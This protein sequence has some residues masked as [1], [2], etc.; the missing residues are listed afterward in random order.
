MST[1]T[2]WRL[3]SE[4]LAAT[5]SFDRATLAQ[6]LGAHLTAAEL[7]SAVV[8]VNAGQRPYVA[9][10]GCPGCAAGRCVTGCHVGL[11]SRTLRASMGVDTRLT[12]VRLGFETSGYQRYLWAWP[13]KKAAQ[14]L[15]GEV[16]A[17]WPRARLLARWRPGRDRWS[18]GAVIALGGEPAGP[19]LAPVLRERSWASQVIPQALHRWALNPFGLLLGLRAGQWRGEPWLMLPARP[20]ASSTV[21]EALEPLQI[22]EVTQ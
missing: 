9:L 7:W 20:A 18:V 17:G 1:F 13:A 10:H 11:L 22:A 19:D 8:Q 21:A 5:G 12:L 16:L 2:L 6:G 3:S 4:Q 14:P 15:G